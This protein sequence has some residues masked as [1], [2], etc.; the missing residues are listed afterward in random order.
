MSVDIVVRLHDDGKLEVM[1][2]D[3]TMGLATWGEVIEQVTAL[4]HPLIHPKREPYPM[5]T[6]QE[7]ERRERELFC[8]RPA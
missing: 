5:L 3:R 4:T 6:P 2:G 7:W 8:E 1:V